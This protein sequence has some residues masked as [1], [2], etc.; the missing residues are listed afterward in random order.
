MSSSEAP[1]S[2]SSR[3]PSRVSAIL[4]SCTAI[5]HEVPSDSRTVDGS[6]F[7]SCA[8]TSDVSICASP[9]CRSVQSSVP[10][11]S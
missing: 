6:G 11:V 9:V 1:L 5:R 7:P 8:S 3:L 2:T 4:D 10:S